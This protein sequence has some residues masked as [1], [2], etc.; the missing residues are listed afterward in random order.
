MVVR[1]GLR[2]AVALASVLIMSAAA[3]AQSNTIRF[4]VGAAAGGAIDPYARVIADHMA[5]TMKRTIIIENKPGAN[6]NIAIQMVADAPADGSLVWVGTQSMT[7][8]NPSAYDNLR[9]SMDDFVPLIRGVEAPMVLVTHP[10]VPAKTLSELVAWIKTKPGQLNYA[11]FNPGTPSHFFGFQLNQRFGLDLT[12]LPYRGSG[13]Q[14]NDLVAG[15]ALLGFAQINNTAPQIKQGNLNA[16]AT[17]GEQRSPLLPDVPT[18][19]EL[20]HPEFTA[21]IWFGLLVKKGTPQPVIDEL[22]KAAQAAHT[23]PKVKATLEAQGFEVSGRT[24]SDALLADIKKQ[25]LRW[26]ELVKAAGFKAD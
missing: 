3:Q 12:H 14:A 18:F 22:V 15:H 1:K 4:I 16:I 10:S 20:K 19:A 26:G 8:I 6:G 7:E 5:A 24:G 17:T 13:L 9:W 25:G 11:S 2:I 21:S 23:D